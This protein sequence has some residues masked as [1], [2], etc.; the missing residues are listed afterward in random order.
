MALPP[1][2]IKQLRRIVGKR[3]V[4]TGL[5]DRLVFESDA[6]T[7]HTAR[8]DCVVY[9]ATT[10]ECTRVVRTCSQAGVPFVALCPHLKQ[11]ALLEELG[12]PVPSV[13]P[14]DEP[15]F[16]RATQMVLARHEEIRA[17]LMAVRPALVHEALAKHRRLAEVLRAADGRRWPSRLKALLA[18]RGLGPWADRDE[19]TIGHAGDA[20]DDEA[21][22]D[23]QG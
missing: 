2:L 11:Q 15:G 18:A 1:G 17:Q 14:G 12:Y 5:A 21:G 19:G 16:E 3:H 4:E 13:S 23:R 22:A 8:P 10:G 7:L 9:P 6:L 20:G